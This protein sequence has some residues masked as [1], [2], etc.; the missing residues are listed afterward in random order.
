MHIA[1][2]LVPQPSCFEL[3]IAVVMLK[4]YKLSVTEQI[5][6]ELIQAVGNTL[7][8]EIYKPIDSIL[9]KKELQQQWKESIIVLIYKKSG[10]TGCSNYRGISPNQQNILP[11]FLSRC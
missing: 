6:A 5:P 7:S 10:K 9:N 8:S 11:L 4:R 2:S 3:E 1:E